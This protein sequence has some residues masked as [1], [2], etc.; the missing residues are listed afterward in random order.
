VN[1][2]PARS[3][4][5][6][7]PGALGDVLLSLPALTAIRRRYSGH[8]LILLAQSQIGQLLAVCGVVAHAVSTESDALAS[9]MA[10]AE[11]LDLGLKALLQSCDHVVAWL[12]DRDGSLRATLENLHISRISIGSPQPCERVHQT[13][14]FLEILGGAAVEA[15]GP[16][17]YLA[18]PDAVRTSARE[19]LR[20]LGVSVDR[21]YAVC[22]P[23]SGSPH[24]CITP[25]AMA[26]VIGDLQRGGIVPVI[27]E[28]PADEMVVGSVRALSWEE[29][30]VV[31][32]RD[33]TR[34]A[35]VLQGASLF[36][37]HDSGLT[38]LAAALEVPTVALFGPTDARQWAPSG[39]H[40]S[41]VTGAPCACPTWELVRACHAKPCLAIPTQTIT[42]TCF[43]VLRRYHDVTKS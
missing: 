7:H 13:R 18:L 6:I 36:V 26:A 43:S 42:S 8:R 22:H 14:R 30:P 33:L 4:L 19:Y 10:G 37:G 39:A 41:I 15:E 17:A 23:G 32:E 3:V 11:Q 34:V 2:V 25:E 21:R 38:H 40:V 1:D 9:L 24:K 20:D 31:R 16:P 12:S 5:V 27:A 35:A 29:I 28:G